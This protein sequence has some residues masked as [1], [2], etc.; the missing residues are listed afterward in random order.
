MSFLAVTYTV[1][2]R[3]VTMSMVMCAKQ[4]FWVF[5][6][7]PLTLLPQHGHF[8]QEDIITR[9]IGSNGMLIVEAGNV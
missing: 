3:I 9:I 6:F 1:L 7:F 4:K 8:S 2:T 5:S